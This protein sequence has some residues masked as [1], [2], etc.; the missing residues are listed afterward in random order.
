M[1]HEPR[2]LHN[3]MPGYGIV[4]MDKAQRTITMECWPRFVDP[5]AK[6]AK[7][8]DG[9][10][11]TVSQMDNYG[12]TPFGYLPRLRIVQGSSPVVQVRSEPDSQV[13]YTIRIVGDTFDPPVFAPGSYSVQVGARQDADSQKV[14]GLQPAPEKGSGELTIRMAR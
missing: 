9:W 12:A 13:V 5:S 10:P 4:R 11:R 2:A 8:Y 1:G 6:D 3:K 7:Q 14:G